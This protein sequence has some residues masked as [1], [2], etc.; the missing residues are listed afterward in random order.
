MV[1]ELFLTSYSKYLLDKVKQVFNTT[2]WSKANLLINHFGFERKGPHHIKQQGHQEGSVMLS[3]NF[4]ML[5]TQFLVLIS[6]G[7]GKQQLC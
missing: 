5:S 2:V 6:R 7:T 3:D 1:L 4:C